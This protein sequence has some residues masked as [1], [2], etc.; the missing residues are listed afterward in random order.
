MGVYELVPPCGFCGARYT[1]DLDRP[2]ICKE[3]TF[4]TPVLSTAAI[5]LGPP[6]RDRDAEA[7]SVHQILF[8]RDAPV[9]PSHRFRRLGQDR[10]HR[11]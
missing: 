1:G 9:G 5:P 7:A 4:G 8:G 6:P 3:V 2:H 10:H 11:P